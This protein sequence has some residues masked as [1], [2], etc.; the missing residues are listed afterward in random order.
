MQNLIG[1]RSEIRVNLIASSFVHDQ[2]MSLISH[3]GP[4]GPANYIRRIYIL[5]QLQRTITTTKLVIRQ[6]LKVQF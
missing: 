6:V 4:S 1:R 5:P 3:K 2:T